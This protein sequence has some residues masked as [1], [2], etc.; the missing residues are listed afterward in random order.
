MNCISINPPYIGKNELEELSDTFLQKLSRKI[1]PIPIEEI[2]ELDCGL[3]LEKISLEE[4]ILG[5]IIFDSKKIQVDKSLEDASGRN[6]FTL[7]HELAHWILHKD[8]IL[9]DTNYYQTSMFD[10]NQHQYVCKKQ[11]KPNSKKREEWQADYFAACLLMPKDLVYENYKK[12]TGSTKP[13]SFSYKN[14]VKKLSDIFQVSQESM[15]IR[16]KELNLFVNDEN[17]LYF[18]GF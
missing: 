9:S 5:K 10:N 16:L 7:A 14:C 15:K 3:I 18:E 4:N 17:L 8:L 11:T 2:I 13:Q 1:L 6:R 12:I